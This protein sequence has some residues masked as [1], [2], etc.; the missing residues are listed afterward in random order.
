[1]ANPTQIAAFDGANGNGFTMGPYDAGAKGI[2][3]VLFNGAIPDIEIWKSLDGGQ[4]W[5]EQ[6]SVNSA[7][8]TLNQAGSLFDPVA[9]TI[10]VA[11]CGVDGNLNFRPFSV[12]TSTWGVQVNGGPGPLNTGFVVNIRIAK[13]STG[14]L[15]FLCG[16]EGPGPSKIA[17]VAE[18]NAGWGAT[19][20]VAS[21]PGVN[22]DSPVDICS[23]SI[24]LVHIFTNDSGFTTGALRH[25]SLNTVNALS[26]FTVIANNIEASGG[27]PNVSVFPQVFYDPVAGMLYVP[28]YDTNTQV[29]H[30][31]SAVESASPGV[32]TN[33][34]MDSAFLAPNAATLS[35]NALV[36]AGNL[37]SYR[38]IETGVAGVGPWSVVGNGIGNAGGYVSPGTLFSMSFGIIGGNKAAFIFTE[39]PTTPGSFGATRTM[40][41]LG[42]VGGGGG[43]PAFQPNQILN[44]LGCGSVA[45]P[46][47]VDCCK[48]C[49]MSTP[50]LLGKSVIY[51]SNESSN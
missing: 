30:I 47:M 22:Q 27:G 38:T 35:M 36:V 34:N 16:L 43:G 15:V 48:V 11:Y 25:I 14:P 44:A 2:F 40:F 5:S 39:D 23:G 12:N 19:I 20:Q 9:G 42:P 32:W 28:G 37:Q 17:Q 21:N 6:D 45:L 46:F 13:R 3:A 51:A 41:F 24:G 31:F 29:M 4:T 33:T 49:E 18:Y 10:Y 8:P 50:M 1:M 26:A 7:I